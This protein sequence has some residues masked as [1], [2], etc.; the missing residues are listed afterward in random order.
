MKIC[1]IFEFNDNQNIQPKEI[2]VLDNCTDIII[3]EKGNYFITQS[4]SRS[5][6]KDYKI[7][8]WKF[9][10]NYIEKTDIIQKDGVEFDLLND[11][12]T[13]Y[14]ISKCEEGKFG[15]VFHLYDSRTYKNIGDLE[16]TLDKIPSNFIFIYLTTDLGDKIVFIKV[17]IQKE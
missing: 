3:Q 17:S 1:F 2:S 8:I 15:I 7:T 9:N 6:I 16:Y 10:N 11:D 5:K 4:V 13:I 12:K 14:I